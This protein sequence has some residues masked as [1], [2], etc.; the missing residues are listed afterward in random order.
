[1][2]S[3]FPKVFMNKHKSYIKGGYF[4]GGEAGDSSCFCHKVVKI[5][6]SGALLFGL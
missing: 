6:Q 1:M 3:T 5:A 2:G 4:L